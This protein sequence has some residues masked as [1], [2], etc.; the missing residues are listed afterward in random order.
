MTNEASDV[1]L[2]FWYESPVA[3]DGDVQMLVTLEM[4]ERKN[5]RK[6]NLESLHYR[7]F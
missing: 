3:L 2:I 5:E 6:V 7:G 4:L 1:I